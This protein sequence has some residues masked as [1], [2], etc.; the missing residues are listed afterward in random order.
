MKHDIIHRVTFHPCAFTGWFACVV[1]EHKKYE[2]PKSVFCEHQL[3]EVPDA[4]K[5][6]AQ[7]GDDDA[8]DLIIQLSNC[9]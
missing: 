9:G 6:Y 1:Q 2:S 3:W 5:L 8:T 4:D 7:I